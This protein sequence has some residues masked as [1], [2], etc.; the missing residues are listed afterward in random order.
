[1]TSCEGLVSKCMKI[2]Q[3]IQSLILVYKHRE[4]NMGTVSIQGV[5]VLFCKKK[6]KILF[7]IKNRVELGYNVTKR[8]E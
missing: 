5:Q 7:G 1:M 6:K 4:R 8:T 2:R 3:T